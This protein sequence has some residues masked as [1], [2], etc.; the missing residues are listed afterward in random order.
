MIFGI[1]TDIVRIARMDASL[2]RHGE[3]F[4]AR[5]LAERERVEFQQSA[6]AAR[7]LAKRFAAKEAFGK[8]LGT[9]VAVP[10]TLHAIGVDHDALGKPV[11]SYDD[12]LADYLA[13]RGLSAH[14]SLS[15]EA[16]YVVAFAL[17]ERTATEGGPV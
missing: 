2:Q 10:A 12:R 6:D 8:A 4:A 1:G 9:G 13:E 16:E 17:I 3:R 15:D 14:L 11:F 7:F 5:I